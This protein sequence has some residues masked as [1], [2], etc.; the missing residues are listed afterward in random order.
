MADFDRCHTHLITQRV[1]LPHQPLKQSHAEDHTE[2]IKPASGEDHCRRTGRL[3]SRKER[4]RAGRSTTKQIF[5]LE[6]LC[7]KHLQHQQDLYQIYTDFKKAFDRVWHAALLATTKKY[8]ISVNF[9]QVIKHL[10]D[11]ATS[12][13]LFTGRLYGPV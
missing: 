2:Q 12:A 6:I 4:H 7:E 5:N 13:V 3:Q 11:K 1:E 8:N 9:I 10:Y